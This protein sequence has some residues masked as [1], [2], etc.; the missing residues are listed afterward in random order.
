M[1]SSSTTRLPA[2]S[3]SPARGEACPA[4][5]C[6]LACSAASCACAP[7]A[8]ATCAERAAHARSERVIRR[9]RNDGGPVA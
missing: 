6:P 7:C 5:A 2:R 3:P 9:Y 1:A 4:I 8:C